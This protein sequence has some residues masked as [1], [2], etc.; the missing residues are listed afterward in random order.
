M[1]GTRVKIQLAFVVIFV[2][3][4]AAG[5]L[6]LAAYVR[7]MEA[8]R[9]AIWTGRF[10]RERFVKQLSEAVGLRQEQM[11]ALNA[12]LEEARE[13]FVSLRRRLNPQFEE[14]RKRVRN[15]IRGILDAEQQGRFDAFAKR[16]EEARRSEEQSP[17]SSKGQHGKP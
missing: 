15:Q 16:W 4:F 2:L 11:G 5:A 1:V 8:G 6:S 10:D 14:V 12:V 9:P 13:E 3:G 17:S 7:R